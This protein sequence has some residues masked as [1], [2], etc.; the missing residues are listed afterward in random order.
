M[1]IE[2][3][4]PEMAAAWDGQEGAGWAKHADHYD[5]GTA[6]YNAHLIEGA[7]ISPTDRILDIGCGN[8]SSTRDAARTASSGEALGVDLSSQMLEWARARS[9]AEGITNVEFLQ[10]DAQVHPFDEQ[11]FDVAISRFGGMFFSDPVAAF[12]NIG[13]ALR[14]DGR[15]AF[16]GWQGLARNE[17][18]TAIREALAMGRTLPTPPMSAPGLLGLGDP[19]RVR[20]ILDEAG[21]DRIEIEEASEQFYAG[22]DANDAFEFLK[23]T[24]PV[25]G[26]LQE[27]D[28]ATRA[29]ALE[30]LRSAI[31]ARETADG[32][33]FGSSAW[34]ITARRPPA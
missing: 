2:T 1:P 11:A 19:D 16:A 14:E 3:A 31:A 4:N 7:S 29:K 5:T 32:V 22:A 18:L 8:G 6:R 9:R 12:R 34:L 30:N 17:W 21:F 27:L 20:Q 15:L 24:G 25:R 13:R 26:L 23:D 10:A 33:F 28:D